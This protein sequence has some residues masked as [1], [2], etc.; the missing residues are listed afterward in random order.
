MRQV[1]PGLNLLDRHLNPGLFL[2]WTENIPDL[3]FR[4]REVVGLFSV[5]ITLIISCLA[6]CVE[7]MN[8]SNELMRSLRSLILE[9]LELTFGATAPTVAAQRPRR[10]RRTV[11]PFPSPE[12]GAALAAAGARPSC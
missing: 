5:S 10:K 4:N 6:V 3:P 11:A 8:S 9:S 7:S 1:L 2:G 12:N